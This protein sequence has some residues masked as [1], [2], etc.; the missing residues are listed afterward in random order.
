MAKPQLTK[1]LAYTG[2]GVMSQEILT[3]G[4]CLG[5]GGAVGALLAHRHLL[6]INVARFRTYTLILMPLCGVLMLVEAF[7]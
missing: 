6:A 3:L 2:F 4:L 7:T 5:L 1:L